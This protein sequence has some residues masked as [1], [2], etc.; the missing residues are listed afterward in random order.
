MQD[1]W[2]YYSVLYVI[3]W[4]NP[5]MVSTIDKYNGNTRVE[6]NCLRLPLPDLSVFI[7]T[8]I[9]FDVVTESIIG[10]VMLDNRFFSQVSSLIQTNYSC[11]FKV[12]IV[13]QKNK[14][15]FKL[16][17]LSDKLFKHMFMYPDLY[18]IDVHGTIKC[19][20]LKCFS[21][22]LANITYPINK[23]ALGRT[24]NDVSS[25]LYSQYR[26]VV[27]KYNQNVIHIIGDV[28][29]EKSTTLKI[30]DVNMGYHVAFIKFG[31]DFITD[32]QYIVDLLYTRGSKIVI[33]YTKTNSKLQINESV[34][35]RMY[36]SPHDYEIHI[37]GKMKNISLKYG[38]M[39][40]LH[41]SL[42][43]I[44]VK[45]GDKLIEIMEKITVFIRDFF[46][47][48]SIKVIDPNNFEIDMNKMDEAKIS[49][50]LMEP[51]KYIVEL[52]YR[53]KITKIPIVSS[54]DKLLGMLQFTKET[55]NSVVE[56]EKYILMTN[57]LETIY[58]ISNQVLYTEYNTYIVRNDRI[59]YFFEESLQNNFVS[60]MLTESNKYK[61]VIMGI[62]MPPK[63]ILDYELPWANRI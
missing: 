45:L 3:I 34:I 21:N 19:I 1:R 27:D 40:Y 30:V 41:I 24:M 48:G 32:I 36:T 43:M 37:E 22:V 42:E 53:F 15:R 20:N 8:I 6:S 59:E 46:P 10:V 60:D 11:W 35:R 5:K 51:R 4:K 50:F 9:V 16:H 33:Y 61:V 25:S 62:H 14:Y 55:I 7:S 58:K 13:N 44:G 28:I 57:Y 2:V 63:N 29:C 56:K 49:D 52:D 38:N 47:N 18:R 54:M 31:Q 23:N 12:N 26:Y 39:Q 17:Q